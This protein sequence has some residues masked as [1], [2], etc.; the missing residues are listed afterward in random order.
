MA[1]LEDPQFSVT[2]WSYNMTEYITI[3]VITVITTMNNKIMTMFW[4]FVKIG[5]NRL[6]LTIFPILNGNPSNN[7]NNEIESVKESDNDSNNKD[8]Q[9]NHI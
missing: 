3:T 4:K 2:S 1:T 6:N 8:V 7:G 5:L 9:K